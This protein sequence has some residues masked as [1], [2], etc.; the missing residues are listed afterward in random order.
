MGVSGAGGE[1]A[2]ARN[3]ATATATARETDRP[4]GPLASA[5]EPAERGAVDTDRDGDG[6]AGRPANNCDLLRSR[7]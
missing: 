2:L 4:G 7:A 5:R 6:A 3:T 1:G